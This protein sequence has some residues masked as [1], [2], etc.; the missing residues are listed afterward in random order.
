MKTPELR[1]R[2]PEGIT[3]AFALAGPI[4]RFLACSIDA[5]AVAAACT[6][7]KTGLQ[8]LH[9]LSADLS[10]AM[11]MITY[12]VLSIGYGI[13]MEWAWRGQ[14]LG[15]RLLGL[16]VLDEGLL[17][18][19]FSQIVVRNL[20]RVV[21]MLPVFYCV[22]GITA[23]VSRR[24]QRLGDLAA[25]TIVVRHAGYAEPDLDQLATGKYNSLRAHPHLVARLRQLVSP[26]EAALAMQAVLRRDQLH[27]DARIHL[28]AELAAGFKDQVR[29]PPEVV[30]PISDEQFVRN[31]VAVLFA[32]PA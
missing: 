28:F 2:T 4:T 32:A 3:F 6:V 18:L 12:F 11:T 7:L 9:L 13:A 1:I 21:D 29:F 8:L 25:H 23:L 19:Q 27:P 16:R 17:K 10:Q 5:A 31:V 22:G 15:K 26:A 30:E 14:T 20:L 24:A